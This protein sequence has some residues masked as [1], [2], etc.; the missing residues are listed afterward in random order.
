MWHTSCE[1]GWRSAEGGRLLPASYE[2][3]GADARHAQ[4][5]ARHGGMVTRYALWHT[6]TL[7][8]FP[9][10]HHP[11]GAVSMLIA[12]LLLTTAPVRITR[13]ESGAMT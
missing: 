12:Q 6:L 4:N 1:P 8:S 3:L 11:I 13:E 10:A 7:H 5:K 9:G 2:L